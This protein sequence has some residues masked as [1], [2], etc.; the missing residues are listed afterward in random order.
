MSERNV[1]L[2]ALTPR[3]WGESAF[4]SDLGMALER[5]G[6]TATVLARDGT[7]KLFAETG[8][9]LQVVPDAA[10]PFLALIV[11]S[12]VS[13]LAPSGLVLCD[14][15]TTERACRFAGMDA[16]R[17]FEYG[18][19]VVGVDTWDAALTGTE[20]DIFLG[21]SMAMATRLDDVALALRPVPFVHPDRPFACRFLPAVERPTKAVRR[22]VRRE[23][24]LTDDDRMVLV[25][26]SPWQHADYGNA[27]GERIGR[28]LPALVA[29]YVGALGPAVHLVHIGPTPFEVGEAFEARYHW[30]PPQPPRILDTVLGASDLLLTANLSGATV[31]KAVVAEV[32]VLWLENSVCAED[33]VDLDRAIGSRLTETSRAWA[34]A[35]LPI[36]PFALWPLGFRRFL[37][38]VIRGNP[39]ADVV[40]RTELLDE[41]GVISTAERLLFDPA[42][43][44]AAREAE[45]AY[46]SAVSRLPD[47]ADLIEAQAGAAFA[48]QLAARRL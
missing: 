31:G 24:G 4:A 45:S 38:P 11:D 22:H 26:T 17:L 8:L 10:M 34:V 2:L 14:I 36:Y 29:A 18:V 9:G 33:Q 20:A 12:L 35:N 21:G 30:M 3:G 44:A 25:C 15:A 46:A 43:S 1:L 6:I 48:P 23:F 37:E 41:R 5:R 19:P 13:D 16:S 40:R 42:A 28:S 39:Y 7:R 32:P 47:G 27:D